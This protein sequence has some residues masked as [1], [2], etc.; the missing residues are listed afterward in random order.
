M[1]ARNGLIATASRIG[2]IVISSVL[3]GSNSATRELSPTLEQQ[4]ANVFAAL[5]GDIEA[6]GRTLD[7]ITAESKT[8]RQRLV[9]LKFHGLAPVFV[10]SSFRTI[11]I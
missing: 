6:P 2:S 7:D 1:S 10:G 5:R 9:S 4:V 8:R 3:G 11:L